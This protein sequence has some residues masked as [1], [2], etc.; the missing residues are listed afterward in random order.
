MGIIPAK[1]EL[2]YADYA[3]YS[4]EWGFSRA[5]LLSGDKTSLLINEDGTAEPVVTST[6]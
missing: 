6:L 5:I 2:K 3:E 4:K 1:E